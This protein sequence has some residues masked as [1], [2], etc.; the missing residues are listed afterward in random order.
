[1]FSDGP[2]ELAS[3]AHIRRKFFDVHAANGSPVAEE[4][5]RRIAALYAIE[6]QCAGLDPPQRLALRQHLSVPA[7]VAERRFPDDREPASA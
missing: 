3:L 6:Q 5:L 1:M 2:T 7:L 4:A